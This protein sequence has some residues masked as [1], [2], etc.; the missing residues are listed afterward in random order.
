MP[1]RKSGSRQLLIIVDHYSK[2]AHA[3][4]LPEN[5]SETV[6]QALLSNLLYR[7]GIP[8]LMPSDNGGGFRNGEA[9]S[10]QNL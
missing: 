4:S 2:F 7:Y 3:A 5:K 10:H 1:D 6:R 9:A 8:R